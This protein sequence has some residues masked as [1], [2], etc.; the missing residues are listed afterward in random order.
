M[1]LYR[2]IIE[3]PPSQSFRLLS[4]ED[5]LA[6]VRMCVG[7][8]ESTPILGSGER[9][10]AHRGVEL[11]F[12]ESGEGTRFVGDSIGAIQPPELV[13]IGADLPHYWSGL[14]QSAGA[15]AQFE[16]NTQRGML[17]LPEI[18]SLESLL[19]RANQ[20]LLFPTEMA[21]ELGARLRGMSVRDPL[22]RL[23]ELLAILGELNQA[24]TSAHQLSQKPF[25]L[26]A[27]SPN[28]DQIS[29][30]VGILIEHFQEELSV[31]DIAQAVDLS[32]TTLSR[33]FRRYTGRSVID[34]L[35]SVRIDHACRLLVETSESIS[36]IAYQCGFSNLSHFNRQFR[37]AIAQPPREYR[38]KSRLKL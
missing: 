26:T 37:R 18:Q 4:W 22:S 29:Q 1:S 32:R 34:F 35:N 21:A 13:L 8:N 33:C 10:H 5:C 38:S 16:I 14:Q 27:T 19:A 7:A 28:A 31:D 2:E 9:W 15:A 12:I 23:T 25:S 20:G 11:T 24:V 30:A 17:A 36:T 3:P 6:N